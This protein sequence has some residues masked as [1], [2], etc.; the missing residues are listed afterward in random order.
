MLKMD[1]R[2]EQGLERLMS[3]KLRYEEEEAKL[4]KDWSEAV[5]TYNITKHH[6]RQKFCKC[7]EVGGETC[8]ALQKQAET[9]LKE[10]KKDYKNKL[11]G[12]KRRRLKE[13]NLFVAEMEWIRTKRIEI[14]NNKKENNNDRQTRRKRQNS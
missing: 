3:A 9:E 14:E 1:I 10:A 8:E 6:H 7:N 2:E 11:A 4:N 5:N 13:I 12:L